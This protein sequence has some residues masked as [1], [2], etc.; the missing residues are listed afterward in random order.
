MKF[1]L[2]LLCIPTIAFTQT[3]TMTKTCTG[4][5]KVCD[6]TD[7]AVSCS[8]EHFYLYAYQYAYVYNGEI[9]SESH[10]FNFSGALGDE[11][12]YEISHLSNDHIIYKSQDFELAIPLEKKSK[13]YI[14]QKGSLGGPGRGNDW[15]ILC[16]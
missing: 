4:E 9:S 2:M 13:V 11:K 7:K 14:K 10:S 1:L 8:S 15:D 12:E 5:M 3:T 6:F 16:E